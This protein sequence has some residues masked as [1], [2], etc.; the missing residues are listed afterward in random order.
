MASG[1]ERRHLRGARCC[2]DRSRR[3]ADLVAVADRFRARV[4]P[5]A[6]DRS[7]ANCARKK[8]YKKP[9]KAGT[10]VYLFSRSSPVFL[11][12]SLNLFFFFLSFV[13]FLFFLLLLLRWRSFPSTTLFRSGFGG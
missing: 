9:R 2:R 3:A 8:D 13:S 7:I 11:G 6:S 5:V 10:R 12:S 4:T 1:V